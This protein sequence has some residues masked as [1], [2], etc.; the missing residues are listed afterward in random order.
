MGKKLLS[1]CM[2]LALCLGLLPVTALAAAEGAPS[3]LYVGN[4]QVSSGNDITYWSTDTSGGLVSASESDS[5]N[6]KYDPVTVTLTLRGATIQGG[7]NTGP[8]SFGSGIYAQ[9]SIGQSVTLTIKLIGENTITGYYG[10]YVNAEMSDNSYGT[11]ASLTI[12]GENNGSLKVSGSYHGIY[13]KSGTGDASLNINDAS[14]VASSSSSDSGY[15]GVYVQSS[16]RATSSPQLSLKV[17][18]GSLTTSG[19]GNSDGILFSVGQSQA[20]GATTSLTVSDNAIVRANGGIKASRVDEPTPSGTGIVFDGKEGTVYGDVILD[21]SLTINQ[22]ETLTVPSGAELNCNGKLTNNGTINVESGGNLEGE[23]TSGTGTVVSAPKI[24]TESLDS[25]TVGAAYSQALQAD[26][27]PTL[28]SITSGSLPDGLNLSGSTIS[29]TP[30]TA[31]TSTFTVKAENSA[32][33]D[34][35][36]YTLTIQSATVPVTGVKLNTETLELFTSNTATLTATVQPGNATNKNVTW[37]SNNAEVATVE[38]G[39]VTAVGAGETTI[40]VQTQDG[41]HTATCTVKVTQSAYSISADT[42]ALNFGSV[43]TGYAQPAAQTVTVENTGNQTLTLTQPASTGSFEVGSLSKSELTAGEKATFTVQP[44]AGL[45]VG[46]Y[47]ENITVSGTGGATVTITA[48]FTVKQYSSGGGT[49]TKTPSQQA[50]D[51][52]E[53]AKDGSTVEIKLSTGSTKLDKEVFEELAGR[54]VTLEISLPGGVSWTVNGQDIP[55]NTDLTDLDLGVTLDASTI[56]VSVVNTITGA[57]DTIQ[58]S[59]KHDGEFGFTM[60]LS[61]PL[62]KTNAGYW[63]NLYWYN[64]RTE[65][66]EFQQAARIARDGTAEFA[67]DHASDY[68][69]VIDDRSHEPVDLPFNDVAEGYWAYDAIQ[70]V[71]GEGLMAGTSGST[72][73]PEGTTTRGQIVTILWRLSGSPVVNYLMDFDDVDPAAYYAEAIRWATSEGI[74]GGYGGGLFGPDDPIT[75]EQLAVMLHR[76]AQHEGFDVSIGEDTNILSYA[77]AFDVSEYAVSALQWACGAGIISGTGDGS[78]LTPQGEATRAQAATVLMRFC[79]MYGNP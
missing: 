48:S 33:S 71:Y 40:T 51:K 39:T 50:V 59:L 28:W 35:K 32:G 58:I 57:V 24:T 23:P 76:Y 25:G 70:Y 5:W 27:A 52:I 78:T 7:T 17:N 53:S 65:E 9:C 60:T 14:V 61:A 77:D 79:N 64:E 8:A 1:L 13:V 38:G 30:T 75:R 69:I 21:E 22:G 34:S 29:G 43:Y 74:A 42:T 37:S 41:N 10:I 67:L 66:L 26:N 44:K 56:P 47:S 11:D 2:A 36:E 62:G 15:A 3:Q 63:A 6:V 18:G 4:Q 49:P 54:D 46:T 72:F 16:V 19:T 68:A 20:T 12:T 73:N 55:E 31:G 45:A